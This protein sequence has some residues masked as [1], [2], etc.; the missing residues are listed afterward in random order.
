LIHYAKFLPDIMKFNLF[1]AFAALAFGSSLVLA[2][3][4]DITARE[5][6]EVGDFIT[7]DFADLVEFQAREEGRHVGSNHEL[8]LITLIVG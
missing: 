5:A 6:D 3:P 7:R 2:V 8:S 4:V 1:I